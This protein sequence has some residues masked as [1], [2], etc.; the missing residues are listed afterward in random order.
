MGK[1]LFDTFEQELLDL[2]KKS[3]IIA[4]IQ[5]YR[6]D[7]MSLYC[8]TLLSSAFCLLI[9]YGSAHASFDKAEAEKPHKSFFGRARMSHMPQAHPILKQED[10]EVAPRFIL[11]IDGGGIRGIIPAVI[12]SYVEEK[13]EKT[14]Q[15]RV[16]ERITRLLGKPL[17]E[18][19]SFPIPLAHSFDI[20]TGTSVG[21]IIAL[22]L[23]VPDSEHPSFPKYQVQTLLNLQKNFGKEVFGSSNKRSLLVTLFKNRF[24]T[25]GL[26][27]LLD[28]YF[29]QVSLKQAL[30][31]VIVPAYE[32][33]Q[34]Q[35]YLFKRESAQHS[36]RD[37]FLIKDAARA[38]SAAPTYL[39]AAAFKNQ[40]QEEHLF[41]DG[42]IIMNNPSMAAFMQALSKFPRAR[43]FSILSLG[44]GRAPHGSLSKLDKKGLL[45]WGPTI[46]SVM[47]DGTS[48]M[49]HDLLQNHQNHP[50]V[51]PQLKY[52]RV[53]T[54]LTKTR[55]EMDNVTEDNLLY[56]AALGRQSI[57]AHKKEL[58]N[59][60][61]DLAD[62]YETKGHLISVALDKALRS[63]P[64]SIPSAASFLLAHQGLKALEAWGLGQ[65]ILRQ[66]APFT[67]VT[68]DLENNP[69]T[70]DGLIL[71]SP[72]LS[73]VMSLNVRN[74]QLTSK[75]LKT[76]A[77]HAPLLTNLNIAQNNVVPGLQ[78]LARLKGLKRL[79]LS[80]IDLK[81]E[82]LP[83]IIASAPHLEAFY[84]E[85]NPQLREGGM[86]I[87]GLPS[88][89][90]LFLGRTSATEHVIDALQ[91]SHTLTILELSHTRFNDD[92][93]KA[94]ATLLKQDRSLK[95]LGLYY[96]HL[97]DLG[98]QSFAEA[99]GENTT[100]TDLN[101]KNN[102]IGNEG[103]T[104]LG[105]S[106]V[107]NTTLRRLDLSR[108]LYEGEAL[109][110]FYKALLDNQGLQ[111]VIVE[112]ST[113]A[114]AV[115]ALKELHDKKKYLKIEE[116]QVRGVRGVR[117]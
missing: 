4:T 22:G 79:N 77:E 103:L 15:K 83:V 9:S 50:G 52:L 71:L 82:A 31:S 69:L 44:T 48:E 60:I 54:P 12:L 81:D 37:D 102:G 23:A 57:Q 89:K 39:S 41:V 5:L 93:A 19:L 35:V 87:K 24:D 63:S 95:T 25:K 21:G 68:L 61:E 106:L 105:Q 29:G 2:R 101:L 16:A 62:A 72:A 88:L 51:T 111:A 43:S 38:T 109:A 70:D 34:E 117:G 99:L 20:M 91:G 64:P 49:T 113:A 36:K 8:R 85:R 42:G 7:I 100:L 11:S 66:S 78:A 112:Y 58:I 30:V 94:L 67:L 46:P 18:E 76:L 27:G 53:Q 55:A 45:G 98:A 59:F 75:A 108:N 14:I 26:E 115:A 116:H 40:A 80:E 17:S 56:L 107:P 3:K 10:Q 96:N 74:T 90:E 73:H 92:N 6:G 84:G 47:M 33:R 28:E 104:A 13:L 1:S 65:Y 114:D 86:L 110:G 97:Q 32:L